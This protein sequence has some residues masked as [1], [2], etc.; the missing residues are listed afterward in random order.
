MFNLAHFVDRGV[1]EAADARAGH[2]RPTSDGPSHDG[3][4]M[5]VHCR[6]GLE[7]S[8]LLGNG[9]LTTSNDEQV[10]KI[11]RIVE[12]LSPDVATPKDARAMLLLKGKNN[13]AF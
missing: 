8:I 7:N 1:G 12:D 13:V 4:I 2:R 6:V 11:R 10:A 3:A 9:Q 5:G